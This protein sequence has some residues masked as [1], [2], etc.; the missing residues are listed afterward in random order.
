MTLRIRERISR[1]TMLLLLG[2]AI[3]G[4]STVK[5]STDYLKNLQ[6]AALRGEIQSGTLDVAHECPTCNPDEAIL[7]QQ[8][9]DAEQRFGAGCK[10]IPG[11]EASYRMIKATMQPDDLVPGY[12]NFVDNRMCQVA[13]KYQ[14][15]A[16]PGH[17]VVSAGDTTGPAG[18]LNAAIDQCREHNPAE[19]DEIVNRAIALE[20]ESINR[21]VLS[22]DYA[23]AK[24]EL[25]IYASLP[26]SNRQR[27]EEWRTSI[28]D[29]E[30][31]AKTLSMQ[32]SAELKAM[33]CD[34]SYFVRNP[35][36]GYGNTVGG[37]NMRKGGRIGSDNPFEPVSKIDT[38]ESRMAT[39]IWEL[40]NA[41][42][43]SMADAQ[44]MLQ[45]AYARAAKDRSYCGATD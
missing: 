18:A 16:A 41:D 33:V 2:A 37:L 1:G 29:E 11:A 4:C 28:A 21:D 43:I 36:T 12:K 35:E 23:D 3:C 42:E 13:E 30:F 39:L 17:R 15:C 7:A 40:S 8:I 10:E 31:A 44:K 38:K 26:R 34:D 5:P 14:A 24:P 22:G 32:T 6:Q 45:R 20:S 27:A 19:A 25:R 9:V